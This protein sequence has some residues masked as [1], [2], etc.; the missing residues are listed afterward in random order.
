MSFILKLSL[1]I[2]QPQ[3][4]K[5]QLR[6]QSRHVVHQVA[7]LDQTVFISSSV[8]HKDASLQTAAFRVVSRKVCTYKPVNFNTTNVCFYHL[9][10]NYI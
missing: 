7:V 8:L 3:L 9:L 4:W 1:A 2:C 5:Q 6:T 10:I